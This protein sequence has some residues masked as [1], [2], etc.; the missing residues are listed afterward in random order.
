MSKFKNFFRHAFAVEPD[1]TAL[2]AEEDIPSERRA[3]LIERFAKE[4][5]DRRLSVP[6]II[7][8]EMVKPLSFLGSQAMIFLEPIIQ[9][10]FSFK[11]YK[12]VYLLLEKRE[13]VE[14]LLQEI[15]KRVQEK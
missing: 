1:E 10:V 13:N 7:F 6:A 9:S 2:Y 14:R 8:L 11:S 3:E 12:E 5:V 4:I 15:E